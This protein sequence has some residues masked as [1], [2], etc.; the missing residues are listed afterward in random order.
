MQELVANQPRTITLTTRASTANGNS[1]TFGQ[2]LAWGNYLQSSLDV[3]VSGTFAMWTPPKNRMTVAGKD[4]RSAQQLLSQQRLFSVNVKG[5][6]V[7][8][9][10]GVYTANVALTRADELSLHVR[11]EG[12]HVPGSPFPVKLIAGP[13]KN[14]AAVVYGAG[15][16]PNQVVQ[17]DNAQFFVQHFDEYGNPLQ[18]MVGTNLTIAIVVQNKCMDCWA[19]SSS[20]KVVLGGLVCTCS[21]SLGVLKISVSDNKDGS[22]TVQ[23]QV[24]ESSQYTIHV[25]S[26]ELPISESMF[27]MQSLQQ[28]AYSVSFV[29][30][31][32]AI[33]SITIIWCL[34]MA[35][36]I[37]LW[38]DKAIVAS[39]RPGLQFCSLFGAV[40]SSIS[41]FLMT[42][43]TNPQFCQSLPWLRSLGF[44][45]FIVP[46][47]V[48]QRIIDFVRHES[49]HGILYGKII[50]PER[51]KLLTL[52]GYIAVELLFQ[53]LWTAVSP[54]GSVRVSSKDNPILSYSVCDGADSNAWTL[55]S[56]ALKLPALFYLLFMSH[57]TKEIPALLEQAKML[58]MAAS[59]F[60]LIAVIITVVSLWL[61]EFRSV[62]IILQAITTSYLVISTTALTLLPSFVQRDEKV[63]LDDPHQFLPPRGSVGH[64]ELMSVVKNQVSVNSNITYSASEPEQQS[65]LSAI[66][67]DAQ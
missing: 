65:T 13:K 2:V 64:A 29:S 59:N 43:P 61:S 24:P 46:H 22:Q 1:T 55:A 54:L 45:L 33:A 63:N 53:I 14:Q 26:E 12:Q 36:L 39:L 58:H 28:L 60:C 67:T 50:V 20:R 18:G 30:A 51:M 42:D 10:L 40:V 35:C 25:N 48:L 47:I 6:V 16:M 8:V 4:L 9:G 15:V 66:E 3:F 21:N 17:N 62:V 57:M 5:S 34:I 52:L 23:Y 49:A 56:L 44:C 27:Q 41:L 32:Q 19:S 31:L 38:K 37:I 11:F 7:E